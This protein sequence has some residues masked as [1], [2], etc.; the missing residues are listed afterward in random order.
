MHDH[1]YHS[2]RFLVLVVSHDIPPTFEIRE[3]DSILNNCRCNIKHDF[4]Q[5][6]GH[7]VDHIQP[8]VDINTETD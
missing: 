2:R 4:L 8:F 5:V 1:R 6:D 7:V 3:R